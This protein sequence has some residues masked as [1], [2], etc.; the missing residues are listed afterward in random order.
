MAKWLMPGSEQ[1]QTV[2]TDYAWIEGSLYRRTT[3]R[4]DRSVSYAVADE[5]EASE[6]PETWLA[7]NGHPRVRTWTPCPEPKES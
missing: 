4:S 6:V 7:I 3:D 2:Q 1:G 5:D